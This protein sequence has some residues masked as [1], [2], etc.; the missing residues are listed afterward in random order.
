MHRIASFDIGFKNFAFCV[1]EYDEEDFEKIH[2]LR[3]HL[4][5]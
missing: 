1:E 4:Q 5:I 2:S 3:S